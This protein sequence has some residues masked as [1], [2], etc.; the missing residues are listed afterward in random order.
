MIL[1]HEEM[2]LRRS[3]NISRHARK[4]KM[5]TNF[6]AIQGQRRAV[7]RGRAGETLAPPYFWGSEKKTENLLVLVPP[8]DFQTQRRLCWASSSARACA[9]LC[10]VGL[11]Y[12]IVYILGGPFLPRTAHSMLKHMILILRICRLRS[13]ISNKINLASYILD[14]RPR[15]QKIPFCNFETFWRW[16]NRNGLV[17][18]FI[19]A[20]N[21]EN[22]PRFYVKPWYCYKKSRLGWR[23]MNIFW[24]L[25]SQEYL[26]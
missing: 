5:L 10:I 15:L 3:I 25:W 20:E 7:V 19:R 13:A 17:T 4:K 11:H 1:C 12:Y 18:G 8:P 2:R 22:F 9:L 21:L 24:S 16:K 26:V 23:S 14:F 6:Y